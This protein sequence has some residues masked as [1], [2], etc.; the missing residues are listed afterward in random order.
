[1]FAFARYFEVAEAYYRQE[2]AVA[3]VEKKENARS[4]PLEVPSYAV[5]VEPIPVNE[6]LRA[7]GACEESA[8]VSSR[9][10]AKEQAGA[11]H[12]TAE[13][14]AKEPQ[15]KRPTRRALARRQQ[16]FDPDVEIGDQILLYRSKSAV[17][18]VHS[19]LHVPFRSSFCVVGRSC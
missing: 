11:G 16:T 15:G 5:V 12:D 4:A 18:K 10:R 7:N 9:Q 13:A 17:V 14:A 6:P 3:L 2:L 19:C 8:Y 1:V